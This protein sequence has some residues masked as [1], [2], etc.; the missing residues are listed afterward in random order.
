MAAAREAEPLGRYLLSVR[1]LEHQAGFGALRVALREALV[2]QV[3]RFLRLGAGHGE[4][5]VLTGRRQG[6]G[7]HSHHQGTE[8]ETAHEPAPPEGPQSDP[9]KNC[10]HR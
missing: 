4:V 8:P 10:R 1:G 9:V 7:G 5:L 6:R 2:Q 3:E